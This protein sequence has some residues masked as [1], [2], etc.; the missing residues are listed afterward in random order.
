M[1]VYT[2]GTTGKP[3]GVVTSHKNIE[4]QIQSMIGPW[5]WTEKDHILHVLPLHHVH[6]IVNVLACPLYAGATCEM[7]ERFDAKVVWQR[8]LKRQGLNLFMAVPTIYG[9]IHSFSHLMFFKLN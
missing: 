9:K 7:M 5:E 2:S 4:S 1:I 6:G 3:K 8:F